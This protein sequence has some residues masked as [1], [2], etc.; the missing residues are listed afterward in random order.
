MHSYY[1][2]REAI[3]SHNTRRQI[4]ITLEETWYTKIWGNHVFDFMLA[5]SEVNAN[6]W[7]KHFGGVE[8]VSTIVLFGRIL[9]R[10]LINNLFLTQNDITPEEINRNSKG[11]NDGHILI[12]LPIG[13]KLNGN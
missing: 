1:E 7:G 11:Q 13:E 4:L 8:A 6:L 3:D 2:H 12:K 10:G 9:Y 5:L